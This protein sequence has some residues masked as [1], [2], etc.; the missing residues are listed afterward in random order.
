[1]GKSIILKEKNWRLLVDPPANAAHNM[2]VDEA[3]LLHHARGETPPTL[4]FYYWN[5]PA[6]SIGYFQDMKREIDIDQCKKLGI[7]YVRRPTGGRAVLHDREITYSV[8]IREE[9]FPGAVLETYRFISSGLLRGLRGLGLNAELARPAKSKNR[10]S[11]ACFDSPSW[12][13]L[14]VNGKKLVGSAQARQEGTLLQHGSV[15]LD[16]DLEKLQRAI[17]TPNEKMRRRL[18][19]T[20]GQKAT[21]INQEL[22]AAGKEAAAPEEVVKALIEGF[23]LELGINFEPGELTVPERNTVRELI[24]RKYDTDRWNF[25]RNKR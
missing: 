2:A 8:I 21:A 20:I 23:R 11:S 6:V 12:Y 3:I 13:E 5:P 7:D 14:T 10:G 18:A 16:L 9:L 1:M 22:A 24:S 17:S 19:H 4:R 25:H 15:L